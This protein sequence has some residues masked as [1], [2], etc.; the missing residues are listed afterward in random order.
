MLSGFRK[1]LAIVT[2]GVPIRQRLPEAFAK[3]ILHRRVRE[4]EEFGKI[5]DARGVAV[6][7]ADQLIVNEDFA[8]RRRWGTAHE[9]I[10]TPAQIR[11]APEPH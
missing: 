7:E 8:H 10:R 11:P 3:P 4:I 6:G 2:V 1:S 5:N 9:F